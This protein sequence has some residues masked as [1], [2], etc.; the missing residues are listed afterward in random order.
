MLPAA[1]HCNKSVLVAKHSGCPSSRWQDT[2]APIVTSLAPPGANLTFVNVGANKGYNVAEF[3]QRY[4]H[5]GAAPSSVAW[6]TELMQAGVDQKLRVRYGC[7]LCNVC[8]AR[9]PRA[10]QHLSVSV[11]AVEMVQANARALRRL[12]TSFRVPGQVHHLAMSNYTGEARYR[13]APAVGLEH[14]EL[15]KNLD[16]EDKADL[17]TA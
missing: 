3:L 2:V 1:I 5:R 17:T 16:A 14:Y 8:K 10:K 12:F 13:S 7:G 11:H 4:H 6:H 15:G 9:P